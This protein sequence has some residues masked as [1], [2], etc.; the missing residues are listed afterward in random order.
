MNLMLDCMEFYFW[1]LF[2]SWILQELTLTE[3][4]IHGEIPVSICQCA[5]LENFEVSKDW[6]TWVD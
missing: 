3:N 6:S 1:I 2:N 5:K 4:Y